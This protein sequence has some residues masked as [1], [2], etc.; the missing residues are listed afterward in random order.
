LPRIIRVALV[1][2]RDVFLTAG[3]FILVDLV[4]AR[5]QK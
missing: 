3:P 4:R 2:V 1:S 5:L